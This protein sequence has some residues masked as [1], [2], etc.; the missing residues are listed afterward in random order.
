MDSDVDRGSLQTDC[1]DSCST[2]SCPWDLTVWLWPAEPVAVETVAVAGVE[3]SVLVQRH[4]PVGYNAVAGT[5]FD[6]SRSELLNRDR[7]GC[8]QWDS[9]EGVRMDYG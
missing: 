6:P 3:D 7:V 9:F 5:S 8:S 1:Q 2:R 4:T